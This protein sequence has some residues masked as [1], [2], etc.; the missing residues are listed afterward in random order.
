MLID[1]PVTQSPRGGTHVHQA[2]KDTMDIKAVVTE[3]RVLKSDF[4][5]LKASL[6]SLASVEFSS[7]ES[8]IAH[9]NALL[10]G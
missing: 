9:V 4:I 7:A 6:A 1:V 2:L 10:Q 8:V 3:N 5:S